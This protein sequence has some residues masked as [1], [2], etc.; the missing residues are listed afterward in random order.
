LITY[1]TTTPAAAATTTTTTKIPFVEGIQD[2]FR[3]YIAGL[4]EKI[5]L[6]GILKDTKL[7]RMQF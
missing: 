1:D 2:V 5:I 4:K 3:E 6:N 7:N